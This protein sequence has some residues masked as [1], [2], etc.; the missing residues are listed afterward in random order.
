MHH[1]YRKEQVQVFLSNGF[2]LRSEGQKH[3]DDFEMSLT[4]QSKA[5]KGSGEITSW[6]SVKH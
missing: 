2:W 3:K 5:K 4:E 1:V 6:Q